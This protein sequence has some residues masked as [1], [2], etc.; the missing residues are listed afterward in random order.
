MSDRINYSTPIIDR[1][2]LIERLS[3]ELRQLGAR[4]FKMNGCF[5]IVCNEPPEGW[6]LS[7]SRKDRDPNWDEIA[8]ARYRLLADVPEMAMYL[9]PLDEY[10]N[11]HP[12]VF[13]LYEVKRP[14]ILVPP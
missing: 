8:T 2:E 4:V 12:F 11:I 1:P 9:P 10:V 5:C 13:H 14:T 3:A 6:H 7:I